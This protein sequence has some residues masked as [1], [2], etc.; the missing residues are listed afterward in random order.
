MLTSIIGSDILPTAEGICTRCPIRLQL[1]TAGPGEKE[2]GVFQGETEE[3]TDLKRITQKISEIQASPAYAGSAKN[4]V[5]KEICLTLR[6]R[7][8]PDLTLVDLPGH[9]VNLV[10][11]QTEETKRNVEDLIVKYASD[12]HTIIMCVSN[13]ASDLA[14]CNGISLAKKCDPEGNR[15]IGVLT[16]SDLALPSEIVKALKNE[17]HTVKFK[18]GFH[19]LINR[20]KKQE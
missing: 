15:T 14:G 5:D 18:N 9:V 8:C 6:L 1:R 16:K 20:N 13:G 19:A 3:I 11:G 12:P 2:Y 10:D 17:G 7:T 4:I